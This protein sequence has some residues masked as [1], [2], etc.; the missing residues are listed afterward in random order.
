MRGSTVPVTLPP[1]S[2]VQFVHSARISSS[3]WLMYR[4]LVPSAASLRRV[5]KSRSTACGVSTEVGSSRISSFGFVISARTI[6]TRWRSPTDSVCTGRSGSTS[7]PYSFSTFVMRCVT[8]ARPSDLSRPSQTF[9][10]AVRVSNR[11][12]CW[13]T[14]LMPS[15][16]ASCGL[17]MSTA[18]PFQR[19]SPSSGATAP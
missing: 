12:K 3:L 17:R 1:R 5:T 7:R 11:L 4:M 8:S 18:R 10:A 14:M 15:E 13:N 9:S 19:I 2:T 16:R 6:S